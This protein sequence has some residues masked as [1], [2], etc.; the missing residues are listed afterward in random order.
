M[1]TLPMMA[2]TCAMSASSALVKKAIPVPKELF[3][4]G[5][6]DTCMAAK[7][8]ANGAKI[9]PNLNSTVLHILEKKHTKPDIIKNQEFIK[10]EKVYK[11]LLNQKYL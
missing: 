3:G 10:N 7:M 8:V 2:L 4:W 5:F 6:N 9:I 11:D 1:W